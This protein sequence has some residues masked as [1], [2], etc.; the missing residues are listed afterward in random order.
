MS[1]YVG[2]PLNHMLAAESE[3]FYGKMMTEEHLAQIEMVL[4]GMLFEH[5]IRGVYIKVEKYDDNTFTVTPVIGD[6]PK[7]KEPAYPPQK[8]EDWWQ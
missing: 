5:E 8:V 2:M 6:K 3:Q 4:N 7:K 1:K